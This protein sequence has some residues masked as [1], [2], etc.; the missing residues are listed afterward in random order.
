MSHKNTYFAHGIRR[1]MVACPLY[2]FSLLGIQSFNISFTVVIEKRMSKTAR[3][4][5]PAKS[6]F[7][8]EPHICFFGAYRKFPLAAYRTRCP[9]TCLPPHCVI[10]KTVGRRIR[11]IFPPVR[12][13]IDPAPHFKFPETSKVCYYFEFGPSLSRKPYFYTFHVRR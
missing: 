5:R 9:Y 12:L 7:L 6:T 11:F 4:T 3:V 8:T 1:I 13:E 10:A 2:I